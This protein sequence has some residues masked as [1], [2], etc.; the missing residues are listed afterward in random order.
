MD[1]TRNAQQLQTPK[2]TSRILDVAIV[3]GGIAGLYAFYKLHGT[4]REIKLFE[5]SDRLGGKIDTWRVAP[6]A[7]DGPQ[8]VSIKDLLVENAEIDSGKKQLLRD[9]LAAEFGPMRI[10][11]QHQPHLK[12]LLTD[13]GIREKDVDDP[14]E[15]WSDLVP[16][17]PYQAPRLVE[18]TFSLEGEEGEQETQI[19]LLLLGLRRILESVQIEPIETQQ[20]DDEPWFIGTVKYKEANFFWKSLRKEDALS[21][22]Y[23]KGFLRQWIVLMDEDHYDIIRKRMKFRGDY[24]SGMGFWNVLSAVMSH[25]AVAKLRDWGTFYHL[26]PENP[27]AAEWIIFWLRALKST[28]SLRGIRGGMDWMVYRLCMKIGFLPNKP[29]EIR[30]RPEK[31]P[32]KV[33]YNTGEYLSL[34]RKL[35]AIK[36]KNDHLELTFKCRDKG[37]D[38]VVQARHVILALPKEPLCQIQLPEADPELEQQF[39]SHLDAVFGFP[40]LKCFF[41]VD[42]PYWPD[43]RQPNQIAPYVPSRELQFTKNRDKTKGMIMLYT[44]R[45]GTQFWTD[46]LVHPSE[47]GAEE[48]KR[49]TEQESAVTWWWR[50]D[51]KETKCYGKMIEKFQNDRLLRRFIQYVRENSAEDITPD[52]LLVAGMRDW[53]LPPFGGAAHA[54][55]PGSKSWETLKYLQAFKLTKQSRTSRLH[56][57][58]EAYSKYHGFIEGALWSTQDVVCVICKELKWPCPA[59]VDATPSSLPRTRI[60]RYE[61]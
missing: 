60:V 58:G 43:D 52:R 61:P 31:G 54:W 36:E 21:R 49:V 45:P 26:L 34:N 9:M 50:T 17:R 13:L 28:D 3:G 47:D 51:A 22:R 4:G 38:E 56:V 57:C 19:D 30:I 14:K 41:F 55:R 27:N 1:I 59:T 10:E 15:K 2:D 44:D 33:E 32:A 37:D 25:M 16:F 53:G 20:D 40:L 5:S 8:S 18:P 39:R 23:W 7:K 48:G 12:S 6:A 35:I 11:P 46:Y 42:Q 24:L 29:E